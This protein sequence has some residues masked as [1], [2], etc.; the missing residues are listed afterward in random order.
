MGK[1]LLL[2]QSNTSLLLISSFLCTF[3]QCGCSKEKKEQT[4]ESSQSKQSA[5]KPVVWNESTRIN[6]PA[7][8]FNSPIA[9]EVWVSETHGNNFPSPLLREKGIG[10]TPRTSPLKIPACYAWFVKPLESKINWDSLV[11][12][13]IQQN[14]PGLI[15]DKPDINDYD[16]K[17]LNKINGF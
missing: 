10:R 8:S 16:L 5:P 7:R 3:L 17:H 1:K 13:M 4:N 15:L 11:R 9:L 12:Q 6:Y 2:L 14:I